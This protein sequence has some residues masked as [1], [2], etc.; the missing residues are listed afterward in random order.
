MFSSEWEARVRKVKTKLVRFVKALNP[1]AG[2]QPVPD[3]SE[4]GYTT[5]ALGV[6]KMSDRAARFFDGRAD[7]E[8]VLEGV[9]RHALGDWGDSAVGCANTNDAAVR[10]GL[11]TCSL[12]TCGTRYFWVVREGD[13]SMTRVYLEDE[14]TA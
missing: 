1:A 10:L 11:M 8:K 12:H 4:R 3:L 13:G 6:L 14:Y 2:D 7:K 9:S 5:H